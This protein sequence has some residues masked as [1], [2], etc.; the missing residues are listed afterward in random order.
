MTAM[1]VFTQPQAAYFLTDTAVYTG[2]GIVTQFAPK[3]MEMFFR[4]D[5][6]TGVAHAAFSMTGCLL[7]AQ[8]AEC[9]RTLGAETLGDML[10]ELPALFSYVC[11]HL[12]TAPRSNNVNENCIAMAIAAYL[13]DRGPMAWVIAN[14]DHPFPADCYEPFTLQPIR[15]YI[16]RTN[17]AGFV[18]NLMPGDPASFDPIADGGKLLA[19]QRLDPFGTDDDPYFAIGGSGVLTEIGPGGIRYHLLRAWPDRVGERIAA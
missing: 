12:A 9:L 18:E 11:S 3:V 10:R 6:T 2:D 14:E 4:D 19:A 7:P 17:Q 1:N 8:M 15:E 13:P 16:M 5:L